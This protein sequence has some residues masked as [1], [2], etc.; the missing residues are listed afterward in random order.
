[1]IVRPEFKQKQPQDRKTILRH[2]RFLS[3]RSCRLSRDRCQLTERPPG[4]IQFVLAVMVSGPGCCST[5]GF[6]LR[7]GASYCSLALAVCFMGPWTFAWI[8]GLQ[9][10]YHPCKNGT[11]STIGDRRGTTQKL[12]DKDLAEHSGEFLVRF[13]SKHL[14]YWVM[15]R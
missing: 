15:T 14:L 7:L 5:P 10:P 3:Q 8:C 4:L 9:L 13:A 11:H 12:C 2:Y 6:H 1:M